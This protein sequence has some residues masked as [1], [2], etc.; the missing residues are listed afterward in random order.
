MVS[1][2]SQNKT[3][4]RHNDTRQRV[5]QK[6]KAAFYA[7]GYAGISLQEV[8]ESVGITK[9]ALFNHFKNKQ[10]LFYNVLLDICQDQKR[11]FQAAFD[12]GHN[13][14]SRLHSILME[15]ASRPFFDPMRFLLEGLNQLNPEQRQ[16]INLAFLA[17]IQPIHQMLQEGVDG[18]E[19]KKRNLQ[20][21]VMAFMN[22]MML[23]PTP[24]NPSTYN[25]AEA[26]R[27][28]YINELLDMYLNGLTH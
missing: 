9:P 13:T 27:E 11:A 7:G 1:K 10:E 22:L 28:N 5:L 24:G 6:A 14:Y 17:S 8:A 16:G 2:A 25:I 20:L 3:D 26:E 12:A 18:G 23:L 4:G 21:A 19:L 15:M